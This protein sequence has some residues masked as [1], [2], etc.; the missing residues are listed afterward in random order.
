M[1]KFI[2]ITTLL[3]SFN[4]LAEIKVSVD[5]PINSP[6]QQ[7][8]LQNAKTK[9]VQQSLDK[10]PSIVWGEQSIRNENYHEQIKAIGFAHANVEIQSETWDH[11][12]KI[13]K[14]TASVSWDHNKVMSTLKDVQEGQEAKKTVIQIEKILNGLNARDFLEGGAYRK[15][16][17]AKLLANPFHLGMDINAYAQRYNETLSQMK[18]IKFQRVVEY[19]EM[20]KIENKGLRNNAFVF[21][22][23]FPE[24]S[25]LSLKFQSED[26][27]K[28]YIE[29]K[30]TIDSIAICAHIPYKYDTETYI[31]RPINT[32]T[33]KSQSLELRIQQSEHGLEALTKGLKPVYFHPC[34]YSPH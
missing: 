2:S 29:N 7:I 25:H 18:K 30:E 20:I 31:P 26:L 4:A 16:D 23:T 9:A 21:L 10:L 27:Q 5:V 15:R 24:M 17:E 8:V 14:I 3:L 1:R 6:H 33:L 13:L 19:A 22:I 11:A 12:N 34:E 28:F 32:Q